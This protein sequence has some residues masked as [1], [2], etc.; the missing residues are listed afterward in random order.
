MNQCPRCLHH[1]KKAAMLMTSYG[2]KALYEDD[3]TPMYEV[4]KEHAKEYTHL[5]HC[6]PACSKYAN[7]ITETIYQVHQCVTCE[8][9]IGCGACKTQHTLCDRA[10][11]DA[12]P[13]ECISAIC[14]CPCH[15]GTR[16]TANMAT[17]APQVMFKKDTTAL[18]IRKA[19]TTAMARFTRLKKDV[20]DLG[21]YQCV[22]GNVFLR[23]DLPEY[24][25]IQGPNF[26]E[27]MQ[28]DAND[29][30]PF[31]LAS[32]ALRGRDKSYFLTRDGN[33]SWIVRL[34]WLQPAPDCCANCDTTR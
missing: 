15:C 11:K 21:T 17:R 1:C 26:T 33:Q 24:E 20:N 4:E 2:T 29:H 23:T 18:T 27:G 10:L 22:H 25:K 31:K 32:K 14:A 28:D 5:T 8:K 19:R 6:S 16:S 7:G 3:G 30:V 9:E 34:A 12:L 13:K